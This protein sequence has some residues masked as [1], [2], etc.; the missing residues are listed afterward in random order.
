MSK[1]KKIIVISSSIVGG[2]MIAVFLG[3]VF[4][5]L[6]VG[7]GPFTYLQF[8]KQEKAIVSKYDAETR[9]NEIVFLRCIQLSFMDGDGKRFNRIQSAKSRFRRQY[10]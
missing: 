8:D 7:W 5:G 10:G 2:L 4:T 6:Y 9:K 3:L 1:K